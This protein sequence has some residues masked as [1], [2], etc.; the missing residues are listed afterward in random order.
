[1]A[2]KIRR[3]LQSELNTTVFSSGELVYTED[4]N[5]LY[6]GDGVTLG[7]IFLGPTS[8]QALT[9]GGDLTLNGHNIVGNGN[10]D[11]N[12]TITATG[13]I[14]LG[15]D[16][17]DDIVFGGE[18]NSN[19]IPN[20][21]ESFNLGSNDKKW[22]QIYAVSLFA[23]AV[24]ADT[25]GYHTG[26][27]KGSV[28]GNDSTP[29]VDAVSSVLR[30]EL[31]GSLTGN[32]SGSVTGNIIASDLTTIVDHTAKTVTAST[33][34]G[35]LTGPVTG[36][37]SGNVKAEDGGNI[38]EAGNDVG[39][40][41]V[42]G[43]FFGLLTGSVFADDETL[44][45]DGENKTVNLENTVNTDVIPTDNGTFSLGARGAAFQSLYLT[46][47]SIR[48]NNTTIEQEDTSLVVL[49]TVDSRIPVT[50]TLNDTIT[51]GL[52]TAFIVTNPVGIRPGSSFTLPGFVNLF[53]VTAVIGNSVSISP[54]NFEVE[55]DDDIPAGTSVTF[56]SP[57]VEN[58]TYRHTV[59]T[60][61]FGEPGDRKGMV[62]ADNDFVYV[63]YADYVDPTTSIWAKSAVTSW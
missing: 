59:P 7:G 39:T 63:C 46:N 13:N 21:D 29:L 51:E 28:F 11:I 60:S 6:V 25:T 30:G 41:K 44:I 61:Q 18:V 45:I 62:F 27:V 49:G 35:S 26:D 4:T 9:L 37:L 20:V 55:P 50:T 56:F 10:I 40:S 47:G 43:Q 15:N 3:G 33:F 31:I 48:I 5:R 34:F 17:E 42:N 23:D 53:V 8:S 22:N 52:K 1:M 19:I 36:D 16:D 24:T 57:R 14:N 38:I 54:E 58:S 2:L 32:V 12:G